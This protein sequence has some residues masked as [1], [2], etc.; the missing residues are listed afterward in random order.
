VEALASRPGFDDVILFNADG[1][2]TESSRANVAAEMDGV[3]CTPPVSCGLLAGTLRARL[4]E[5]GEL[6]ERVIPVDAL[7]RSPRVV[8][9]NSVRG[10][11]PVTVIAP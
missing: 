3:L 11:V 4:L 7:L 10:Q 2:I 8:L 1:E 5:T 9:V 6:V